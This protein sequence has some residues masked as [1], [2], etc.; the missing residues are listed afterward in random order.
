MLQEAEQY[1]RLKQRYVNQK[2]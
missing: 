1:L 2:K